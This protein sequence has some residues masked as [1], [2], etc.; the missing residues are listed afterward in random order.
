MMGQTEKSE[1]MYEAITELPDEFI[2]EAGAGD[3]YYI[4]NINKNLSNH[5]FATDISKIAIK[6]CA[7]RNKQLRG[8]I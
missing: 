4:S 3:G 6:K 5:C 7:K 1:K 2:L 8:E